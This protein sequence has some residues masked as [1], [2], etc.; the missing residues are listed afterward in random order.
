M[1]SDATSE[2]PFVWGNLLH[3]SYNMWCDRDYPDAR[4]Y[5]VMQDHLRFDRSL[6]NDLVQQMAEVGM[7]LVAIDLGDGVRWE[8]HP[9]IAVEGAWSREELK[10]ELSRLRGLG[11]EPIP[12]LNFST[13]H[14]AWMKEYSRMV[15]TPK[16]YEVC[17]H[18]IE[19]VI[20]LFDRPR[21][22]AV[23]VPLHIPDGIRCSIPVSFA[24]SNKAARCIQQPRN[25]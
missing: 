7:N 18:L 8:S 1:V 20:D 21:L 25:P 12:K 22:W 3:L 19:E 5:I 15:S 23:R 4:E 9:E 6:W 16:Y 2:Q 24:R 11:L 17:A 14:D 13:A 10:Q